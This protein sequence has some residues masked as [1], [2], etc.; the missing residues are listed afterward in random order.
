[1]LKKMR[2]NGEAKILTMTLDL[3]EAGFTGDVDVAV[4]PKALVILK[5]GA[6]HK[7]VIESL[8]MTITELELEQK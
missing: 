6:K 4:G 7:D 8:R 3:L 5:P 1:M 2:I